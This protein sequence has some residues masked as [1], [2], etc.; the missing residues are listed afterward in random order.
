MKMDIITQ[1]MHEIEDITHEI[2]DK[3][4]YGKRPKYTPKE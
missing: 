3:D 1:I 4:E 2:H